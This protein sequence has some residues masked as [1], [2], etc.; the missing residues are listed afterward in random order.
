MIWYQGCDREELLR[1]LGGGPSNAVAIRSE[2]D[3]N[4]GKKEL[5]L[6][7]RQSPERTSS[8]P[9]VIIA[10]KLHDFMAW[11]STYLATYRPITA[12]FRIIAE[13][14]LAKFATD[15]D[16]IGSGE[17]ASTFCGAIVAESYLRH[18]RPS[19]SRLLETCSF[20]LARTFSLRCGRA[21]QEIVARW[22]AVNRQFDDHDTYRLR[23]VVE[24]VWSD[25]GALVGDSIS[26]RPLI[27][28]ACRQVM[29][30]GRVNPQTWRLLVGGAEE[31]SA[32]ND[33]MLLSRERRLEW[34]DGVIRHVAS[35]RIANPELVP[36]IIGYLFS[37][38][39]PGSLDHI[40]LLSVTAAQPEAL[41][42]YGVC[43][44]LHPRSTVQDY[45][46]GVVRQALRDIERWEPFVERPRSDFG[47]DELD[48]LPLGTVA[49]SQT[50][51]VVEI[52]PRVYSM[53]RTAAHRPQNLEEPIDRSRLHELG[54][55]LNNAADLYY[56]LIRPHEQGNL[57]AR[58]S[59]QGRK[60]PPV[61]R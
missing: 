28:D 40:E 35:D 58:R 32:A 30:D 48:F 16:P 49:S 29:H 19:L 43:A 8:A 52:A 60:P 25:I 22:H 26:T 14:D 50:S 24:I 23:K 21:F 13:E 4:L 61:A 45:G 59:R 5:G 27:V 11:A 41:L 37:Q 15:P 47:I 1:I 6:L 54:R 12:Y 20:A 7:W 9:Q 55:L 3:T 36:F 10:K 56:E 2:L 39:A 17:F 57:D 51:L 34:L 53:F 31:I 18:A 42:W 38:L 33:V 46:S 44:G